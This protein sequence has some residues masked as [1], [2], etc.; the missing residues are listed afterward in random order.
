MIADSLGCRLFS[1]HSNL[2]NGWFTLQALI[3]VQ[4]LPNDCPFA[5]VLM[6]DAMTPLYLWSLSNDVQIGFIANPYV[7]AI[8]GGLSLALVALLTR[9]AP[10]RWQL[11]VMYRGNRA[12]GL[13]V[14]VATGCLIGLPLRF[15]QGIEPA[16]IPGYWAWLLVGPNALWRSRRDGCPWHR[17]IA[18]RSADECVKT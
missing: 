2:F 6:R 11:V 5:F 7:L 18:N 1:V 4:G 17:H 3:Q 12:M 15:Y 10:E 14:G 8:L 9:L 16:A 13:A